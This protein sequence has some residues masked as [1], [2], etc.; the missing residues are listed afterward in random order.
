MTLNDYS[1]QTY[2]ICGFFEEL[3]VSKQM[4][5]NPYYQPQKDSPGSV[6]F[7]DLET[8]RINSQGEWPDLD[9]KVT[10]Y[11]NVKYFKNNTR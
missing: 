3:A 6:Y 1:A 8:L 4:K 2:A 5:I 7:S 11:F 9:F 10:V